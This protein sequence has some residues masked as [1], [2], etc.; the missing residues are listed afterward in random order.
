ML[1]EDT[2][3]ESSQ[4]AEPD[5]AGTKEPAAAEPEPEVDP[6]VALIAQLTGECDSL[7]DELLRTMAE[8]QNIQKRL[9]E[10]HRQALQFASEPLVQQILP[11]LD[12]LERALAA[13]KAG[14]SDKKLLQ[15]FEQIERQLRK[16]LGTANVEKLKVLGE[17]FDPNMHEA[18]TTIDSDEHEDETV[19][20][21]IQPGYKMLDRVIRP[22]K[23]QV[24]KKK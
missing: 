14:A 7:K 18:V 10:Q 20:A 6:S 9:R 19:A 15:G 17:K 8:A 22:A 21:E 11:V 2:K 16:A 1:P 5:E 12:D 23:V 3:Q 13:H 4:A 24:V